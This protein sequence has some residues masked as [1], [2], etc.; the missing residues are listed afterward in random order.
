MS[1]GFT[2]DVAGLALAVSADADLPIEPEGT[3]RKFTRAPGAAGPAPFSRLH[4]CWG[5]PRVPA[6]A[7]LGFDS[8][9]GLWRMYRT[10]AGPEF[11]FTSPA[12]GPAPYQAA[13]FNEDFTE[14]RVTL[15]RE[16]FADRLPVYPLH[17]P[18]DEVFMVH[19]LARGLGIE[20]HGAGV[21]TADGRGFLFAGQS[22]AGKTTM[23]KLWRAEE[24]VTVLSD[25]RI[26][27]RRHDDGIWMYGTPWHGDGYVAEPGRARLERI[28]LLRQGP[29][30]AFRAL[31]PVEAAARLFA[32]S[33]VPFH[34]APGLDF[35]LS[36]LDDVVGRCRCEELAFV[37]DRSV[38][39]FARR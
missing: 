5:D 4:A 36:L 37:P 17:Y 34:D 1:A 35:S 28:F 12:L 18:L 20:L 10:D 39:D 33:F 32:C 24:G 14:G 23:S 6:R 13:A 21:V 9:K 31:S 19:L 3:S 15:R 2:L 25:E 30:N 26:I 11:I 38:L 7:T 29:A 27:V 22:G 16:R 8:G